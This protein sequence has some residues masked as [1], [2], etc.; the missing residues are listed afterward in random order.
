MLGWAYVPSH[1]ENNKVTDLAHK[2][3]LLTSSPSRFKF[4]ELPLELRE[5]IYEMALCTGEF[6]TIVRKSQS[7]KPGSGN[8][9]GITLPISLLKSCPQIQ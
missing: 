8:N 1:Q 5:A 3:P 9:E 4:L 7:K 2:K 6:T